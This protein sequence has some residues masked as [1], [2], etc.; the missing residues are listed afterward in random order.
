M[1]KNNINSTNEGF[2]I[3]ALSIKGRVIL[4]ALLPTLALVFLGTFLSIERYS[5]V[6][7]ANTTIE[8]FSLAPIL[9]RLVHSLQA[10]RTYS[11]G[12]ASNQTELFSSLLDASI[13]ATDN[14]IA[15]MSS[16]LDKLAKQGN[17]L[18]G[19]EHVLEALASIDQIEAIRLQVEKT[20]L[21]QDEVISSYTTAISPLIE[22]LEL[23]A[24]EAKTVD[25][26]QKSFTYISL[27]LAIENAELERAQGAAG[28]GNAMFSSEQLKNFISQGAKSQA[29]LAEFSSA[30]TPDE[31][32][33]YQQLLKSDVFSNYERILRVTLANHFANATMEI[34]AAEWIDTA[35]ERISNL[36]ELEKSVIN[37]LL[38]DAQLQKGYANTQLWII[39]TLNA[40]ILL[41]TSV[42]SFFI[43]NSISRPVN[44]LMLAMGALAKGNFDIQIPGVKN[45]DEIGDMARAVEIFKTSGMERLRLEGES[46][47]DQRI[48]ADRQISV[49]KMIGNF[50]T[51]VEESLANVSTNAEKMNNTAGNLTDIA[52]N[53]SGQAKEAEN[54]SQSASENVQTV[55]AAT[56]QLSASISEISI[57]VSKTNT[58][59]A[60]ASD[61]ANATNEKVT[62]LASAAKNIGDVIALI[63]DIAERTNLLALNT[64]IEAARAGEAGKGFAV[65][66]SEVKSLANQTATATEEISTQIADIQNS[67]SEAVAGITEITRT[68]AEVNTYTSSIASAVEEQ[69]A[70]TQEISQSV[71]QA[72]NG[73][74]QVVNS[75][76]SVTS[77]VEETNVSASKVLEASKEVAGQAGSLRNTIDSFLSEVTAA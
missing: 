46:E 45:K 43:T 27:V 8:E 16:E 4:L 25:L 10:E 20:E 15:Y 33:V 69:G 23:V 19:D 65:V 14:T 51:V 56:E 44:N 49:D 64:S 12:F 74:M 54:S 7:D 58:I 50:R 39:L 47:K 34:S 35:G 55:A 5:Q 70:A 41:A 18:A 77:S 13:I 30:A 42:L 67:T 63:Q 26:T 38:A 1:Q 75:M 37:E 60:N 17:N 24:K 32:A 66:A 3:A 6:K 21:S 29:F 22:L 2:L 73:T 36:I 59:V 31:L 9:A 57:Q 48:R 71:S 72:A 40:V 28:L 76:Q 68:M 11:A 62:A 61:A 52:A 53:T